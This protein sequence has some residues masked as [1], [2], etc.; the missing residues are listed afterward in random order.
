M[1]RDI[2]ASRN[3]L[4]ILKYQYEGLERPKCFSRN[5]GHCDTSKDYKQ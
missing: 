4:E 5:K 2:N 3:I 1:D